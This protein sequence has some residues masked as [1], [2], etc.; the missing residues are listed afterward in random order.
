MKQR[1]LFNEQQLPDLEKLIREAFPIEYLKVGQTEFGGTIQ[2]V[3]VQFSNLESL[4]QCWKEFNNVLAAEYATTIKDE[5]T[6]W[7]FYIFYLETAEIKKPLKYTIENNKFCSRKIV[8][9]RFSGQVTKEIIESII[10]EHITNNNIDFSVKAAKTEN[11]EKDDVLAK[12]ISNY[13]IRKTRKE[14]EE[15][16]TTIL[17][18]IEKSL[19][20]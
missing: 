12:I 8:V 2:I 14:K 3:V 13:T 17:S 20:K 19:T 18:E 16:L 4:D 7:N 1:G 10:S 5:F 15:D 11:F 6:K 9:D